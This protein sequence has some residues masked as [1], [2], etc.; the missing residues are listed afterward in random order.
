M[1]EAG[2]IGYWPRDIDGKLDHLVGEQTVKMLNTQR[3]LD[4]RSV[5]FVASMMFRGRGV[6]P[7]QRPNTMRGPSLPGEKLYCVRKIPDKAL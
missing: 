1:N 4:P 5:A 6:S 2:R 3:S 7:T